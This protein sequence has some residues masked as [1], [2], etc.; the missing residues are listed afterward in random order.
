MSKTVK[1][2]PFWVRMGDT[3]DKAVKAVANHNHVNRECDLPEKTPEGILE[4]N[5]YG[6]HYDFAYN[7]VNVC[8]CKMCTAQLDRKH[9]ARVNRQIRKQTNHELVK[10]SSLEEGIVYGEAKHKY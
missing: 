5:H 6:C 2:R 7:G 3:K 9:K 1:T 10:D 4:Q 8:G